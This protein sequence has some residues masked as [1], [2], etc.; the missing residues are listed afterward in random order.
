[1]KMT[2]MSKQGGR[3][4]RELEICCRKGGVSGHDVE[5]SQILSFLHALVNWFIA[6]G[7]G[8]RNLMNLLTDETRS[9]ARQLL[10]LLQSQIAA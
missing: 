1:M 9:I 10:V 2:G 5:Y 4:L 3:R 7:Y 6:Q 8:R